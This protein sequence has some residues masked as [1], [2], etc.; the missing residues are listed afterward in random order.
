MSK[1][2]S[3]ILSCFSRGDR[4]IPVPSRFIFFCLSGAA[5]AG[6]FAPVY[7]GAAVTEAKKAPN[8]TRMV[9]V[10]VR[11]FIFSFSD[12]RRAVGFLF[13]FPKVM[14]VLEWLLEW[15]SEWQFYLLLGMFG[16]CDDEDGKEE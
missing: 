5:A 6:V 2:Q 13:L 1:T 3:Q 11:F 14:M 15:L 8:N 10:V 4:R 12:V 9:V 7:C 16:G